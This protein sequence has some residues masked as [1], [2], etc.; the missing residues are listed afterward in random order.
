MGAQELRENIIKLLDDINNVKILTLVL[1]Y[2]NNIKN[3][4]Q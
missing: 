2:I 4:R 1:G 3:K